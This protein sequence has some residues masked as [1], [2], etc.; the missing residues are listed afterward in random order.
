MPP[1]VLELPLAP[2]PGL[3]PTFTHWRCLVLAQIELKGPWHLGR[4][5]P[6]QIQ[7]PSWVPARLAQTREEE[8]LGEMSSSN[9]ERSETG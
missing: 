5:C 2:A 1:E 4:S 9:S 7:S 3:S 8:E 6:I